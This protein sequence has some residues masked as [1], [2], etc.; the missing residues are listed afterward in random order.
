MNFSLISAPHPMAWSAW[1]STT[2]AWL[3]RQAAAPKPRTPVWRLILSTQIIAYCRLRREQL[4]HQR[5]HPI[6]PRRPD[7]RR[8]QHPFIGTY[9]GPPAERSAARQRGESRLY[10]YRR[11]FR[12]H[13]DRLG[14]LFLLRRYIQ[15]EQQPTLP[16]AGD[17]H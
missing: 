6:L 7:A 9:L 1:R 11:L 3:V 17:R 8:P 12:Q 4:L 10:V 14:Q 13:R 16:T 2:A 5:Q 15:R